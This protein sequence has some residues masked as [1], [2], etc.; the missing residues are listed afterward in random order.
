MVD[1]VRSLCITIST[2]LFRLIPT[3]YSLFHG[4]AALPSLFET[5]QI[6]NITNN[7]YTIT[8]IV[9]LF[10]FATKAITGIVNPDSLW[11][12]KKGVTGVLK[13]SIIA[14]ALI[15]GIPFAFEYYYEFQTK[16]I[17]NALIEKFVL[18]LNVDSD[19]VLTSEEL[20]EL[21]EI[22]EKEPDK[23]TRK[24]LKEAALK[25]AIGYKIGQSLAQ[26][27]FKNVVRPTEGNKC[28]DKE[29]TD[30][31]LEYGVRSAIYSIPIYG[32][33]KLFKDLFNSGASSMVSG[34][35]MT[36]TGTFWRKTYNGEKITPC[37]AYDLAI[38]TNID[39]S[40]YLNGVINTTSDFDMLEAV[41]GQS[42]GQ[43]NKEHYIFE[44][45][46]WGL[47][48]VVVSGSIV[49]LLILFCIDSAVRLVKMAFLEITAPISI[50]AYIAGGNDMLKK[51]WNEVLGTVI[52]FFLRVAAISFI[53]IVL[54][55]LDNF[56][57]N[58]P[59][60]YGYMARIFIIIGTLIFAKKVPE[61]VEKL[62][63]V[64]LN[65][66]GGIGGR[67]G[68]M[69]GV[70]KVAQNAWKSLGN[71]AKGV[72]ATAAGFGLGALGAGLKFGAHK[73]DNKFGEGEFL[74]R[75]KNNKAIQTMSDLGKITKAGVSQHGGIIKTTKAMGDAA[76]KTKFAQ[77]SKIKMAEEKRAAQLDADKNRWNNLSC[78]DDGT[79]KDRIET[80]VVTDASGNPII[81]PNTGQPKTRKKYNLFD[82]SSKKT[83]RIMSSDLNTEDSEKNILKNNYKNLGNSVVQE[84][85]MGR[86]KKDTDEIKAAFTKEKETTDALQETARKN[87]K[88][89]LANEYSSLHTLFAEKKFND[90]FNTIN[91]MVSAGKLTNDEATTLIGSARRVEGTMIDFKN[92]REDSNYKGLINNNTM[93]TAMLDSSK[94][95]GAILNDATKS[96]DKL[97][98]TA[99]SH[100]DVGLKGLE[101]GDY[102][103]DL[104]TQQR[105][106]LDAI[107]SQNIKDNKNRRVDSD[108]RYATPTSSTSV[109]TPTG[110]T[111]GSS[112]G[113]NTTGSGGPTN[114]GN[115][116]NNNNN[117]TSQQ[118]QGNN[119][120]INPQQ[121]NN[122]NGGL[123]GQTIK[124]DNITTNTLDAQNVTAQSFKADQFRADQFRAD[125]FTADSFSSN[126]NPINNQSN[127]KDEIEQL[128][129]ELKKIQDAIK[130]LENT[131]R[132]LTKE[133]TAQLQELKEQEK[134]Q[135]NRINA[136]LN[137]KKN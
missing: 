77:E 87:G 96:V 90:Y 36:P 26:N 104:I 118:G 126:N 121:N 37:K 48:A 78:N 21:D 97:V 9:M 66:Q 17:S 39:F 114:G 112:A 108:T 85:R 46:F 72:G 129:T 124:V 2:S 56:T 14:L 23:T 113:G 111:P 131:N 5:E 45:D 19:N 51:W 98:E 91:T 42:T 69:A 117:N 15:V 57:E 102:M 25:N 125:S 76:S 8:S 50:M 31:L 89:N 100:V 101:A 135:N 18:G 81:D 24:N 34:A 29:G 64:K 62:I 7:I 59:T 70:G 11:D 13:R 105:D 110:G 67:L 119:Q 103:Y 107:N 92:L 68:Q 74:D 123:G 61:V 83:G 55:N 30:S 79:A 120:N 35:I 75:L 116:Q 44:M 132:Q 27:S 71:T 63:G 58:I 65:L 115:P 93:L 4:L 137:E 94:L 99:K 10:A 3:L 53:A 49:Y 38:T 60:Y 20:E 109:P 106:A 1:F 16:V 32:T 54:I 133:E 22:I 122:Q 82:P 136:K 95:S 43:F 33:S 47:L 80:E 52:S 84:G 12:S 6:K 40:Q 86:I 127:S 28:T 88:I 134:Q 128:T 130:K 41:A 73:L